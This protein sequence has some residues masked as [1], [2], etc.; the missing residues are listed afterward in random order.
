MISYLM[1]ESMF[2][3]ISLVYVFCGSYKS[4]YNLI[5][6]FFE[7]KSK[8]FIFRCQMNNSH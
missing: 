3:F 5:K 4:N 1:Y 2:D 8:N 6:F 7:A